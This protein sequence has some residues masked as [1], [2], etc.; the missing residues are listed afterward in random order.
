MNVIRSLSVKER[1]LCLFF[2]ARCLCCGKAVRPE[3][4]FCQDCASSLPEETLLREFPMPQAL[5]GALLV[6][7]P[8]PYEEGFRETLHRLKFWEEWGISTP[9]G[10]LMGEAARSL[11]GK[12]T[13]VTC[14]PMSSKK[15]RKRGYNQSALLAKSVAKELGLPF[16]EALSQVREIEIQHTLTRP[17]RADNVREAYRGNRVAQGQ[18]ILLV[19]DIVTTGA[20]LRACAQELYQAGAKSVSALCAASSRPR[21]DVIHIED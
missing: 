17:Q 4:L 7:A 16:R 6:A 5:G 1:V 11:P 18:E 10:Q 3:R 21:L 12:F 8:L 2:P 9:L 14:V 20:T 19:D 13:L 15:L